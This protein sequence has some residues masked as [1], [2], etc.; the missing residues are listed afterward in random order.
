MLGNRVEG[1]DE[2]ALITR[3]SQSVGNLDEQAPVGLGIWTGMDG[4]HLNAGLPT[5]QR[6]DN[7]IAD[8]TNCAGIEWGKDVVVNGAPELRAHAT[9]A[10]GGAK[11]EPDSLLNILATAR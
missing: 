10:R 11:D 6:L 3:R 4:R 2:T 7:V 8:H 9:L 1:I 5:R